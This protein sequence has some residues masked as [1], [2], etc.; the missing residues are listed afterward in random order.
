MSI[1]V[2]LNDGS[3]REVEENSSVLDLANLISRN[4]GKNAIV[5]EVNNTL[6]DLSHKLK[7]N[8]EV[9]ILTTDNEKAVEVLRHSISHIMAQAVKRLYKDAKLAIGPSIE[10]GFYYDFDIEKPLT[11]EDLEKIEQEMN[12]IINENLKFE[13]MDVLRE[14]ALNLMEEKNEPYKV[15]LINDLPEGEKISLYKQG[16][17]VD[18]CRGPHIPSTKYVKAFKLTSVAGAYWRGNEKNKML[19][20]VY[21]VAFKD[22]TSLETYLHNLEE[23]KKRD[24]RKLGKELKLFTFAEEGPGF[25]F[26]LPKGVILKNTLIDFWRKLHYEAGYVE[27]ET[28]IML[29]KKLWETSGHWYHYKENMYTSMIDGEEFALKPMNCPGGML[30]YKSEAHSYRDFPMRVGELGRVHRH[31]LSGALHGLMRVRAFTQDD[32]HIFMLPDQ[33]KS[34]IKGVVELIDKVYSK[35]GFKYHVELSTRPEDSMG[36][37]EEWN[38]AEDSLKGALEE[39]NLDFIVNEGDGAFYGP[40][41]DFHLED[42][43]GRTWQCGTIQLDFQLP[44]RFE[45]EYVGSDGEKHRPIVIHRVIFGSIERFIGI[46]IEHFAGKFPTWLA[47]VQVK[48]LPISDKFNDYSE[49]IKNKL[50]KN[51]IRVEM[52]YRN[53]KIGYKI[54]EARNERVPYIIVIGEK[55]ENEKKISLRSR[56]NGDEGSLELKELIDRINDE[57]ISKSL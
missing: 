47:P 9:N 10:N 52:D 57:V 12:N 19:Q 51:G 21:G 25:P 31:E 53:E 16:D 27:V 28:P 22:K 20:R 56:K 14:E 54:R 1:K 38:L 4:L 40:K 17:Y 48:V 49:Q 36:S 7:D 2:K 5:G 24:H 30:V 15:E 8:D 55:E 44:Q 35:F 6:V 34:E 46:L 26:F 32:A 50:E 18:L 13:R 43:I 23:A 3:L 39:L 41:I 42:S 37:D 11:T 29:N 33:I 45:L